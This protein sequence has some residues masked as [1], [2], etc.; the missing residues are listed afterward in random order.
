MGSDESDP[1]KTGQLWSRLACFGSTPFLKDNSIFVKRKLKF[2]KNECLT[3]KVRFL[4][5]PVGES[6]LYFA[7]CFQYM[8]L[9]DKSQNL[10]YS[11]A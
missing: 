1:D 9:C 6:I 8:T 7:K 4:N 3:P 5:V 10:W 2:D 11:F